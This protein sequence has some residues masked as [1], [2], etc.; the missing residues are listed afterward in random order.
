MDAF[1]KGFTKRAQ[2]YGLT[3]K[4]ASNFLGRYFEMAKQQG[5]ARINHPIASM[6]VGAAAGA[7]GQLGEVP[8]AMLFN[9]AYLGKTPGE[10]KHTFKEQN[11]ELD[12]RTYGQSAAKGAKAFAGP[13]AVVGALGVP[14][15][16]A[17]L[18]NQPHQHQYEGKD[19]L[20]GAG[21][22]ALGGGLLGAGSG[23]AAGMLNKFVHN[24][25][26][27]ESKDRANKML[28]KHP[29]ATELPFGRLAGSMFA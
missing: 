19:Y 28:A 27:N 9:R 16:M 2:E 6:G 11:Q 12:D 17:I 23:A 13:N 3:E 5:E 15:L 20:A 25:T 7:A 22:G 18:A 21:L 29:Y 1:A 26:G 4:Q 24:Q 10:R 8:G 14:A